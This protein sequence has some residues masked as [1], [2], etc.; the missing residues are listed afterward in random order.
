MRR[1][2]CAGNNC[3]FGE[4]EDCVFLCGGFDILSER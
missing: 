3:W 2:G 1:I 4:R